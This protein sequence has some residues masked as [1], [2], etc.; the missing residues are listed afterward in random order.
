MPVRTNIFGLFPSHNADSNPEPKFM[1]T[2]GLPCWVEGDREDGFLTGGYALNKWTKE[3][4]D[5][6]FEC[7][8][9]LAA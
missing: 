4:F 7:E 1:D 9:P 6:P 5:G 3:L 2:D 8:W